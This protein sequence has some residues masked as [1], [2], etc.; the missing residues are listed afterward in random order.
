LIFFRTPPAYGPAGKTLLQALIGGVAFGIEAA[1]NRGCFFGTLTK[2]AKGDVHM[3]NHHRC[4]RASLNNEF[5]ISP[6]SAAWFPQYAVTGYSVRYRVVSPQKASLT[7]LFVVA[8][9]RDNFRDDL[10]H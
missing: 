5:D 4:G 8:A 9:S 6:R 2:L 7:S 10:Y 3:R 1:L